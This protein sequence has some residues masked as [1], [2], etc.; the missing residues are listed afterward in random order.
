MSASL[1][2]FSTLCMHGKSL[3]SCPIL[4]NPMDCSLPGSSVHGIFQ[5]E[6]WS[7]LP[8]P[9]P[10]DLPNPGIEPTSRM[11]PALAE[12]FF[13]SSATW[14]ALFHLTYYLSIYHLF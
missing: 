9:P 2:F 12:G 13:T 7:G 14:E 10:G 4:C 3:Q 11:S 6:Y 5:A 1:L 8:C